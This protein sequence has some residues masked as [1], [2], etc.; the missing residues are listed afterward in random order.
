MADSMAFRA[1]A[2]VTMGRGLHPPKSPARR[3]RSPPR[4]SLP[5]ILALILLHLED[6]HRGSASQAF[7]FTL[8][9]DLCGSQNTKQ[10]RSF[11]PQLSPV[12]WPLHA[13]P[14]RL[15]PRPPRFGVRLLRNRDTRRDDHARPRSSPP[16]ADRLRPSGQSGPGL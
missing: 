16:W 5:V 4:G 9:L 1:P 10:K 11:H 6:V 2:S 8:N 15:A 7:M 14:P 12:N 13:V 3:A